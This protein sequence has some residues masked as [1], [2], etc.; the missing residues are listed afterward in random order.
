MNVESVVMMIQRDECYNK[1]MCVLYNCEPRLIILEG[2]YTSDAPLIQSP[3]ASPTCA[4]LFP[5]LVLG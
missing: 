2:S 3:A 4:T 1:A 5:L